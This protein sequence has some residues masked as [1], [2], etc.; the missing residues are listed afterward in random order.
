MT[1]PEPTAVSAAQALTMLDV[2]KSILSDWIRQGHVWNLAPH[3]HTKLYSLRRMKE[4]AAAYHARKAKR[5]KKPSGPGG[6]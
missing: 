2:P 5:A 1:T 3:G 4:L 6:E